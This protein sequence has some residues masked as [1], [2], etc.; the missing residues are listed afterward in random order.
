MPL[1][2]NLRTLTSKNKLVPAWILCCAIA[3][4]TVVCVSIIVG[5]Q[6]R[7][8]DLE[9]SSPRPS[10][11]RNILFELYL[12]GVDPLQ[13]II[14][15]DW[16]I[17][18]DDCNNGGTACPAVNIYVNP[19][20]SDEFL[21][22]GG[23]TTPSDNG[24]SQP[25]FQHNPT[26]LSLSPR[27]AFRTQLDL[28]S[29]PLP[30]RPNL[31]DYPFDKYSASASIFARTNNTEEAVGAW[32]YNVTGA[33][34]GFATT[35]GGIR[36]DANTVTSVDLDV[37]RAMSV[38]LYV[39]TITFGMWLI[40]L[41]LMAATIKALIFRHKIETAVLVL[42]VATMIAFA[43]LRGSMPNAPAG[44]DLMGSL[45]TYVCLVFTTVFGLAYCLSDHTPR[46]AKQLGDFAA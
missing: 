20:C 32:I 5:W 41:A 18:G 11:A 43:Q 16:W 7:I 39:I 40:S 1:L 9:G 34:F 27:P 2:D 19:T 37:N 46:P 30:N 21:D 44:F 17:I 13:N 6:L 4:A 3:A 42:P 22:A 38:K 15:L 12:V 25:A 45:P 31:V 26:T 8:S 24:A 23:S 29:Y 33:A 36:V 14:T 28:R 10:A 35:L